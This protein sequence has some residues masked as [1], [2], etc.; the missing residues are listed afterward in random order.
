[1]YASP[2]NPSRPEIQ[3]FVGA[4]G[5]NN[6]DGLSDSERQAQQAFMMLQRPGFGHPPNLSNL[7][8]QISHLLNQEE[9][10]ARNRESWSC[11]EN[12][13]L[14]QMATNGSMTW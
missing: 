7:S 3:G 5:S 9:I 1:M 6:R 4:N 8:P 10:D 12:A 14:K 13:L 11:E 2:T